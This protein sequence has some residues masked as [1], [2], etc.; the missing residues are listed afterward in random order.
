MHYKTVFGYQLKGILW[1]VTRECWYEL[2][3]LMGSCIWVDHAI[4]VFTV[5]PKRL[6]EEHVSIKESLSWIWGWTFTSRQ[7][8]PLGMMNKT[9]E[10]VEFIDMRLFTPGINVSTG[11]KSYEIVVTS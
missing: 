4:L 2:H 10:L 6:A 1:L 3:F 8:L 11:Y 9:Y 5:T 7:L